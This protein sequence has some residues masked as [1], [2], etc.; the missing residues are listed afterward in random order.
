MRLSY[1]LEIANRVQVGCPS[2]CETQTPSLLEGHLPFFGSHTSWQSR[3]SNFRK[4]WKPVRL[5]FGSIIK[6]PLVPVSCL[7]LG[8]S[9]RRGEWPRAIVNLEMVWFLRFV[10]VSRLVRLWNYPQNASWCDVLVSDWLI[11]SEKDLLHSYDQLTVLIIAGFCMVVGVPS[12]G[13]SLLDGYKT[14][15]SHH[16]PHTQT[17]HHLN[18]RRTFYR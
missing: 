10:P 18:A 14:N 16:M 5:R 4:F 17:S 2:N 3:S 11:A 6:A 15:D 12:V 7:S 1:Q 13:V 9:L 8:A